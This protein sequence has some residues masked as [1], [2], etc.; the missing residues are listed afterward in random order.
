MTDQRSVTTEDGTEWTCV[1]AYA[2]L[3]EA[4]EAIAAKLADQ[5]GR[6]P[7][8]CTPSGG[9]QSVRLKLPEEWHDHISD[10]ELAQ[11]IQAELSRAE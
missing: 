11:A 6:V 3:Q 10:A 9:A 7:V 4:P 1:Q 2:G 5:K 8:V